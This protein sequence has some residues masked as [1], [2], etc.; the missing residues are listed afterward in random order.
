MIAIFLDAP[1]LC[2]HLPVGI[3]T[4]ICRFRLFDLVDL[5]L[6]EVTVALLLGNELDEPF[7]LDFT[8]G[9]TAGLGNAV[10]NGVVDV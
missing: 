8:P 1:W 4:V 3:G 5:E 9:K 6:P 10:A 7:A 2:R